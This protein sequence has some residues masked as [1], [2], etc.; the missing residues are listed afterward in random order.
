MSG[1]ATP[2]TAAALLN[3]LTDALTPALQLPEIS[4]KHTARPVQRYWFGWPTAM[5]LMAYNETVCGVKIGEK[6]SIEPLVPSGW[7]SYRSPLLTL[8][9]RQVQ[10]EVRQGTTL[11]HVDGKPLAPG[12]KLPWTKRD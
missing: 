6:I 5:L 8:R 1:T 11:L 3:W 4:D 10:I 2:E 7:E 9:G 12:S